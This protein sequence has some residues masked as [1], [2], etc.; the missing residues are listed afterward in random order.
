MKLGV[1]LFCFFY[2]W[3]HCGVKGKNILRIWRFFF[4]SFIFYLWRHRCVAIIVGLL[5]YRRT[6]KPAFV[7]DCTVIMHEQHVWKIF[8]K[9]NFKK[10]IPCLYSMCVLL[11]YYRRWWSFVILMV[12]LFL[13]CCQNGASWW[14]RERAD[15]SGPMGEMDCVWWKGFSHWESVILTW[16]SGWFIEKL[17]LPLPFWGYGGRIYWLYI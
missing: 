17:I 16:V 5:L 14:W 2:G 15:T 4:F 8:M 3:C 13:W 9:T 12:F 10:I 6:V 1:F 11:C 7:E